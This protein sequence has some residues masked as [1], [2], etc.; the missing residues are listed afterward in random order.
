VGATPIL[1]GG[2]FRSD[3]QLTSDARHTVIEAQ[4]NISNLAY[5]GFWLPII[6]QDGP[7]QR[8]FY[9]DL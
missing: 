3:C 8:E 2:Y 6:R 1:V 5:I 4:H 9:G 7:S